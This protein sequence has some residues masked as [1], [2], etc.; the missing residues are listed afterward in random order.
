M[1]GTRTVT[2]PGK[3]IYKDRNTKI[4]TKNVHLHKSTKNLKDKNFAKAEKLAE[5][6]VKGKKKMMLVDITDLDL[7]DFESSTDDLYDY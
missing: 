5:K 7:E 3:T 4:D 1:G 6:S 2:H